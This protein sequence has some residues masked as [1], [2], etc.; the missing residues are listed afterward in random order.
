L[1]HEITMIVK[2][3][4]SSFRDLHCCHW[5]ADVQDLF[6]CRNLKSHIDVD[7]VYDIVYDIEDAP[8]LGSL[9]T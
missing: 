7:I 5:T 2:L 1:F 4:Q 9:Y 8:I 6:L 3:G